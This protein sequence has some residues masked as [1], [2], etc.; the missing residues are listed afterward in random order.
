MNNKERFLLWKEMLENQESS[1]SDRKPRMYYR[2]RKFNSKEFFTLKNKKAFFSSPEK[3]ND[4]MDYCVSINVNENYKRLN[5]DLKK[6][7]IKALSYSLEKY[8]LL[9]GK[10]ISINKDKALEISK[11]LLNRDGSFDFKI[12]DEYCT[13]YEISRK[14]K[15]IIDKIKCIDIDK[16]QK[17]IDKILNNICN[18]SDNMKKQRV[19]YCLSETYD[20]NHQW[21]IYANKYSGFCIRYEIDNKEIL[22]ST[23]PIVYG[24][25]EEISVL[26]IITDSLIYPK[27]DINKS[28]TIKTIA[29]QFFT[30]DPSWEGEKEWRISL[31]VENEF[32][33]YVDFPYA[34]AIYLGKNMKSKNKTQLINYAKKNKMEVYQQ[35]FDI[36]KGKMIY[37]K[38]Y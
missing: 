18:L 9:K 30:K 7:I 20:N 4:E 24:F 15:N 14:E 28:E 21:S 33:N 25:K 36:L 1:F 32:N 34:T 31:R 5:S 10:E 12:I 6:K 27:Q 26:S 37:K 2:Y 16:F 3:W 35:E 8:A 23:F 19:F 38:I 11:S 17:D 29:Q 22:D 13:N